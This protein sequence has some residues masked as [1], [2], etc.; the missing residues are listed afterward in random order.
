VL[1]KQVDPVYLPIIHMGAA[2]TGEI[3][4]KN[5]EI[6]IKILSA[7]KDMFRII[8]MSSLIINLSISSF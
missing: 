8:F 6:V 7:S 5:R 4:S 3:V 2:C 1:S